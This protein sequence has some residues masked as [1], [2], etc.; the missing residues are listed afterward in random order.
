MQVVVS[1][2]KA[3]EGHGAAN[4]QLSIARLSATILNNQFF[5]F[6]IHGQLKIAQTAEIMSARD[7]SVH[8]AEGSAKKRLFSRAGDLQKTLDRPPG[9]FHFARNRLKQS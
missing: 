6:K 4:L 5:P 7:V 9:V 1:G 2:F 8:D 3:G